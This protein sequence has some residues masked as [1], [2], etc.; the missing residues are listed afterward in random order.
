MRRS[1]KRVTVPF[2]AP[3]LT[4]ALFATSLIGQSLGIISGTLTGSDGKPLAAMVILN[5]VP[6]LRASGSARSAA[7]GTFTISNLSPGT[8]DICAQV[9]SA[10]YLDPCA[11]EPIPVRVQI[12]AGQSLAGYQLVANLGMPLQVR[13]NDPS[14]V[15]SATAPLSAGQASPSLLVGVFSAR[16]LFQ[17]LV[18]TSVD[19]GGRNMQIAVPQ[20]A[21]ARLYVG[22]QGVQIT[23]A[24]GTAINPA[25]TATTVT[26]NATTTF[27]VTANTGT[28]KP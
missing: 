14:G 28:V 13:I 18:T 4:A 7:N 16:G 2:V 22:G 6:P 3:L 27:T 15:L 17:L 11:W 21:A 19:A 8:Y 5:G 26:P 20:N 1:E 10:G 24:S 25:G 9:A 23:N 12:V